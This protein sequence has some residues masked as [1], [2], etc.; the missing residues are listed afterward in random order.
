MIF[1]MN[2]IIK[3]FL[4]GWDNN[5]KLKEKE[6]CIDRV[7]N[8]SK[9]CKE[10]IDGTTNEYFCDAKWCKFHPNYNTEL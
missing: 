4:E 5:N 8:G 2:E 1:K 3:N 7:F 9:V 6:G 10:L